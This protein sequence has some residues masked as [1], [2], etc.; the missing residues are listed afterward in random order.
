MS[1]K[2]NILYIFH[3]SSIGGGSFC[4]LNMIKRLDRELFNPIIL[5][6]E[7]GPLCTELEKLGAKV[8]LEKTI[9][10]VPY[11][12]S[13]LERNSI[14]K[15]FLL[16]ISVRKV[17]YWIKRSDADIVHINTMMMYPY[18]VAAHKLGRK[19]VVHIR[20]QWPE[21]EHKIQFAIAQRL[22]QKYS[23]RIIAINEA[24]AEMIGV[25]AKTQVVY[26]WIDFKDRDE[27]IDFSKLF[28]NDFKS[29]KVFLFFGGINW[30][31][32]SLELVEVFSDKILS[33][34][35][36]LLIVGCDTNNIEFH[37]VKGF[38]KRILSVFNYHIYN[39][40]VILTAQKDERIV[41]LPSTY[42]VKS[43]IEQSFCVVS[44]FTIPHANLS[45]AEAIWLGTPS[46]S[47]LTPEAKEYCNDGKAALLFSINDKE[48]FRKKVLFALGNED[49]VKRNAIDGMK[50][51]R[52]KFDPVRNSSILNKVYRD[53]IMKNDIQY[54]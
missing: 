24:S 2:T 48:E 15:I 50:T 16:L 32:G 38:L 6:K 40:K 3:V 46:I 52:E 23:D 44:F 42:Q 8:I 37:G 13:V 11:N 17:R 51:V 35:A 30:M 1:P 22:I 27:S 5:L 19:V 4:L 10:I 29:L 9:S 49:I 21:N 54:V 43:L 18:A 34:E 31:K 39:D 45:M 12:R 41:F 14:N 20:E 25:T 36:R 26:D 53:L 47:A 33:K 7:Y 28:G